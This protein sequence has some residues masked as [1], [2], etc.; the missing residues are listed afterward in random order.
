MKKLF[1]PL[2]VLSAVSLFAADEELYHD[3]GTYANASYYCPS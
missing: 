3:D 2:L 1:L